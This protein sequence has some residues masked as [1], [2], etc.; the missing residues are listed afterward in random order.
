VQ[1]EP[2]K[3]TTKVAKDRAVKKLTPITE[4][5]LE[6]IEE[7]RTNHLNLLNKCRLKSFDQV[8]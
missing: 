5:K 8:N 6:E 4:Q 1:D 3:T 7:I 2:E